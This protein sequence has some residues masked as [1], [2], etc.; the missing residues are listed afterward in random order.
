MY[1]FELGPPSSVLVVTVLE[2]KL[3]YK[4]HIGHIA[5]CRQKKKGFLLFVVLIQR[6]ALAKVVCYMKKLFQE[7]QTKRI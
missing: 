5:V 6:F 7:E 2:L 3:M 1:D 4:Y